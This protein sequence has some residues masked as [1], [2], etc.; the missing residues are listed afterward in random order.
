MVSAHAAESD[1]GGE[2]TATSHGTTCT[3]PSLS[4]ALPRGV[5]FKSERATAQRR[6]VTLLGAAAGRQILNRDGLQR[7][8]LARDLA[9]PQLDGKG[10]A[11]LAL[12][13]ELAGL[14]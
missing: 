14:G 13:D 7:T 2:R 1:R 9:H 12:A 4:I 8:A 3:K 6:N 11:V 5:G 10:H